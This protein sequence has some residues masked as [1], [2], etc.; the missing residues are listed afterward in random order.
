MT[1]SRAV[2]VASLQARYQQTSIPEATYIPEGADVDTA[3]LHLDAAILAHAPVQ[4]RFERV[5]L[6]TPPTTFELTLPG[7]TA[8]DI[9]LTR[10]G[11]V[12]AP[13]ADGDY[14]VTGTTVTFTSNLTPPPSQNNVIDVRYL[15]L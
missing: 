10:R 15:P 13:G 7:R 12:L 4:P 6:G 11:L 3:L 8:E 1:L 14:T 9:L 2:K 5:I